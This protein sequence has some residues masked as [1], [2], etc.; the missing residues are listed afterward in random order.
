[1]IPT[2]IPVI[3]APKYE[4]VYPIAG[5]IKAYKINSIGIDIN[6]KIPNL[7]IY[8][9]PFRNSSISSKAFA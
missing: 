2:A 8:S 7:F 6:K 1:M 3:A 5:N 9:A 4:G